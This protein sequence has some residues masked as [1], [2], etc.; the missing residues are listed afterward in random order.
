M[1]GA[2]GHTSFVGGWILAGSESNCTR[3]YFTIFENSVGAVLEV[4][5]I[6]AAL[7]AHA[8]RWKPAEL[9]ALT[10]YTASIAAMRERR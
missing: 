10:F 3:T 1:I 9:V 5:V 7:A 4:T 8:T 6:L 2:M